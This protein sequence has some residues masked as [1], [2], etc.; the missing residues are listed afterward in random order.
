MRRGVPGRAFSLHMGPGYPYVQGPYGNRWPQV[1]GSKSGRSAALSSV[2]L[3]RCGS[4]CIR[5]AGPDVHQPRRRCMPVEA[6]TW[7]NPGDT[8]W[9][10]TAATLVGL[11]SVPGLVVLYGGVMQKRWSINSM[12]LDVRSLFCRSDHLG[13][14]RLQDGLRLAVP[15]VVAPRLLRELH[16][17]AGAGARATRSCRG[18]ATYPC[19]AARR[20]RNRHWSTSS[21]CSPGS[22]RS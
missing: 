19:W 14:L 7:L 13:A 4:A 18:R 22:R 17:E 8:S 20:S 5:R 16:R 12:M 21:S 6:P 1:H 10:M 3:G 15:R 9:Q 11:M 2:G